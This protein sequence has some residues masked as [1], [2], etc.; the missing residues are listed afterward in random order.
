MRR[1]I[2]TCAVADAALLQRSSADAVAANERKKLLALLEQQAVSDD[3]DRWLATTEAKTLAAVEEVGEAAAS[4]LTKVVPELAT[5]RHAGPGHQ[6]RGHH[7]AVL[8]SAQPDGHGGA[9]RARPTQGTMDEQPAPM[10]VRSRPGSAPRWPRSRWRRR[11]PSWSAA[12]SIASG[13][14][15]LA[16]L[17][18]WTGWTMG[19]TRAAVAALDTEEVEVDGARGARA[20][21]RHRAGPRTRSRGS[22]LLPG[23]RPHPDG[24]EGA[25]LVPRRAPVARVRQHRQ[26]RPDV[27]V[28]GRIVGG[29][30]HLQDRRGGVPPARGRRRA[31]AAGWSRRPPR[32]CRTQLGAGSG[33]CRGS[34][35]PSTGTCPPDGRHP[36]RPLGV[37]RA[38]L[39][40]AGRG[41]RCVQG[42]A[43]HGQRQERQARHARGGRLDGRGPRPRSPADPRGHPG[44]RQAR[45]RR[46]RRRLL[47]RPHARPSPSRTACGWPAA[48]VA[49]A[50]RPSGSGGSSIAGAAREKVL[51]CRRP[52]SSGSSPRLTTSTGCRRA[53]PRWPWSGGRTSASRR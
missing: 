41:H 25:R 32:R 11:G 28:D 42:R 19:A 30:A 7:R 22:A 39:Q 47:R 26:R 38:P 36:G 44:H 6:A 52:W 18:W 21:R 34:R 33:S 12:G 49:P 17:K 35:R 27:W 24:V 2:F 4:D 37:G 48:S 50:G 23:P 13:P 9:A 53:R 14:G 51:R 8:P 40:D 43:R 3:P 31:S 1:T 15:T 45:R 5:T 29:W 16:D 20:G 46:D 10:V